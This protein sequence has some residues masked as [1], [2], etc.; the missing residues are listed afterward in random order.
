VPP[1]QEP[2]RFLVG[3]IV[4]GIAVFIVVSVVLFQWYGKTL[5]L[6]NWLTG[7]VVATFTAVVFYFWRKNESEKKTSQIKQIGRTMI[8]HVEDNAIKQKALAFTLK[9][10]NLDVDLQ[11]EAS[12]ESALAFLTREDFLKIKPDMIILDLNLGTGMS[13][14]DFLEKI[15]LNQ[16]LFHIPVIILSMTPRVEAARGEVIDCCRFYLEWGG[17]GEQ[18]LK[19]AILACDP[20]YG[21]SAFEEITAEKDKAIKQ[22]EELRKISHDQR[23]CIATLMAAHNMTEADWQIAC[24]HANTILVKASN[25]SGRWLAFKP[26]EKK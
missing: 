20:R 8:L 12:G 19:E 14:Q 15:K 7:M 13:G 24:K 18:A 9:R 4:L 5:V 21:K 16:D 11:S 1:E 3:K 6:E 25:L 26:D 17:T 22:L 10:L 23:S 2:F